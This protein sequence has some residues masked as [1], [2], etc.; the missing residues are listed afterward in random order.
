MYVWEV[1]KGD[2]KNSVG[3]RNHVLVSKQLAE[4]SEKRRPRNS[5]KYR[6]ESC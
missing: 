6:T 4:T 2:S 3:L 1:K 5:E